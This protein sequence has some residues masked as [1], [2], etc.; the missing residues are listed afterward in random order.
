MGSKFGSIN[1]KGSIAQISLPLD[2]TVRE[3][4]HGWTT[5][6]SEDFGWGT[7]HEVAQRYSR[8]IEGTVLSTEYFDDDYVEFV[9]YRDGKRVAIHI[10]AEYEDYPRKVGRLKGFVNALSMPQDDEKLF[11]AVFKETDPATSVLLMES[12]LGCPIDVR[13]EAL[14]TTMPPTRSYLENYLEKKKTSKLK[15]QTRLVLIDEKNLCFGWHP[16][17]PI[18]HR[19]L[20]NSHSRDN[21]PQEVYVIDDNGKLCRLFE[22]NISG[23]LDE[24]FGFSNGHG[25][26]TLQYN[27][28]GED[29]HIWFYV[30]LDDGTM[31]DKKELQFSD[32]LTHTKPVVIDNSRVFLGGICYNFRERAVEWRGEFKPQLS[33][34]EMQYKDIYFSSILPGIESVERTAV[35]PGV[36]PVLQ[37]GSS[38]IVVMNKDLHM[39]SRHKSKGWIRHFILQGDKFFVISYSQEKT[40]THWE[41]REFVREV[42]KPSHIYVYELRL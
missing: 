10:P 23:Q 35:L 21:N 8:T 26:T 38:G 3:I 2:V 33:E 20:G 17:Y 1:I 7:T 27:S 6:A 12:L 28:P 16:T 14:D 40:Q 15:N 4:S 41:N 37:V 11:R 36:G 9:L 24:H 13:A 29:K 42:T 31:L 5:I 32:G 34:E 25:V 30:F 18:V 39:I 22:L 19:V